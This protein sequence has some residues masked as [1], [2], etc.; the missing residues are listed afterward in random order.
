M[1]PQTHALTRPLGY[2]APTYWFVFWLAN[3]LDK[4][5]HGVSVSLFGIPL[6]TWFGKD[7]LEQFGKY[8]DRLEIPHDG[9]APLLGACGALELGVAVLFGVTLL[10]TKGY[11]TWL[12]T[13]FSA[14]ALM[15]IGFSA[16]DVVA[17]D[18]AELLEHGTYVGVVFI[19][20][21]FVA[22]TQFKPV[23]VLGVRRSRT[24]TMAFAS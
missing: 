16:W 3:G 5:M 1:N 10:G 24:G 17:G 4:F 12:T 23:A 21:A 7:R 19:T 6:F 9:I 20:A 13:A 14:C 22:V 8:F 2:I 11:E 15:F 18:R